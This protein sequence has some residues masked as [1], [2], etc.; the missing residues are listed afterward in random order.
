MRRERVAQGVRRDA[1]RQA[2]PPTKQV[3]PITKPANAER[4]AEVVEEDLDRLVVAAS[5]R[6]ARHEDRPA[7]L[8]IGRQGGP[9]RP[10]DQPDPFLAPLA[11]DP[12]LAATQIERGEVG[13]CELADAEARRVGRLD[14]GPVT[15]RE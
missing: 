3:E 6:A 10:A 9:R 4:P 14:E 5:T 7:V 15:E 2:R 12:D 8:E 1:V 13:R 11:K